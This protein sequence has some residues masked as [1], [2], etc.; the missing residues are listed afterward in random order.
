MYVRYYIVYALRGSNNKKRGVLF[1]FLRKKIIF[2]K[3]N[4]LFMIKVT[5]ATINAKKQ[6]ILLRDNQ[7]EVFLWVFY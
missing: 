1:H 2:V 6:K 5:N 3:I 4:F 7:I